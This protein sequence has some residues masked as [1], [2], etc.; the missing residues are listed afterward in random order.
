MECSRFSVQDVEELTI[1]L[2]LYASKGESREE[3]RY[4]VPG[5]HT[6]FTLIPLLFV[7]LPQFDKSVDLLSKKP[8]AAKVDCKYYPDM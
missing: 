4:N 2:G 1:P 5:A 7:S 3:V 8:F 6:C